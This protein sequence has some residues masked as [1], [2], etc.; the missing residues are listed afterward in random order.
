M[1]IHYA[2]FAGVSGH[3]MIFCMVVIFTLSHLKIRNQSFE[4]FQ[5][6]HRL[7]ILFLFAAWTH[8]AGCF[9]RNTVEPYDIFDRKLYW[10]HCV[11]YQSWRWETWFSILY[12]L[13]R[14]YAH[15]YIQR[16]VNVQKVLQHPSNVLEIRFDRAALVSFK[17]GQWLFL[18]CPAIST[19]SMASLFHLILSVR[20]LRL[21][22]Y[23][24]G[25][26]LHPGPSS[27]LRQ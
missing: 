18:K 16:R 17:A 24:S 27:S 22:S 6:G 9:V 25:W 7:F 19:Y 23:P 1:Q 12:I 11:G 3:V 2:Q 8:G 14:L 10:Q 21:S 13:E 5:W 20:S 15:V 4:A 26:R